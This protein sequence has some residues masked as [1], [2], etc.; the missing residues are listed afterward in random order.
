MKSLIAI[1]VVCLLANTLFAQCDDG[2]CQV[3]TKAPV[4]QALA[5]PLVSVLEAQPVRRTVAATVNLVATVPQ[6]VRQTKP[7]RS[8]AK[9]PVRVL[10]CQPVRSVVRRIFCR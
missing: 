6:V 10:Q 1:L 2:V 5:A 3:P 7:V 8:I 9:I 4:L